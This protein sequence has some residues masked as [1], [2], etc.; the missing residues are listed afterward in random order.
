M[1]WL[2]LQRGFEVDIVRVD[3][4]IVGFESKVEVIKVEQVK[5]KPALSLRN[6]IITSIEYLAGATLGMFCL[7]IYNTLLCIYGALE[8]L[9]DLIKIWR[10]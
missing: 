8:I 4:E 9:W 1:G 5:S 10:E 7:W 2:W 3:G 6:K